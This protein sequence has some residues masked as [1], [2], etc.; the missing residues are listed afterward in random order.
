MK[1]FFAM[2][3][4]AFYVWMAYAMA[5]FLCVAE[6]V[7]VR[8]RTRKARILAAHRADAGNKGKSAARLTEA[9]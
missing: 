2:G 3:G 8:A 4:H 6:I 1:E 5:A 7:S 9:E